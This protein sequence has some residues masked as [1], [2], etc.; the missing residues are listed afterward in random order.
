[1]RQERILVVD[2]EAPSRGIVASLLEHGG[3][4]AV[5]ASDANEAIDLLSQDPHYSLVLSDIMMPGTDG[6]ALLDRITSNH[7]DLPVIMF[8]AVRDIHVATNAFR[9]GAFDYLLKP[10]ERKQLESVV[11]RAA[12]HRRHLQQNA[13]YR[14]HL[15]EIIS[16]RTSRLRAIMQDLERSY[17]ITIE[18]MGDALDLRDQ[19]TEGHSKRVTAYTIELARAMG[20]S[21][22]DLRTIARG[23]FLHDIGK[24][25]TPDAILLKP[26]RLDPTE[27]AIMR[28]HCQRGYEML[29]KIPF[30]CDAAEIVYAHQECFNGTGYPRGL[31]GTH[32][33]LGARIFAIADTL[34][35]MTS[36]RPY[37]KG[38]SFEAARAEIAACSGTQFDPAIV[39]VFLKIPHDHWQ[40]IRDKAEQPGF[41]ALTAI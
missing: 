23:A 38:T 39:E 34:D 26:G 29:R 35:A 2:D 13:A 15:E 41:D 9:R 27:I 32:I 5:T 36:D 20:V 6:L 10:F 12:E 28:E 14:Q 18:A 3:H 11:A 37:R 31:K 4:S 17:D 22:D 21:Y 7:P 8:S 25:A 33:P 40:K 24:I 30:L 1:M 16:T 19:E